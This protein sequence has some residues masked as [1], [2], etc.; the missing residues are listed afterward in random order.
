[1]WNPFIN[2]EHSSKQLDL[3]ILFIVPKMRNLNSLTI[4]Y[5]S[6]MKYISDTLCQ[7][8][9]TNSDDLGLI[10][11]SNT[12]S[13]IKADSLDTYFQEDSTLLCLQYILRSFHDIA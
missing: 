9:L 2:T 12:K 3:F 7:T 8:G 6:P 13:L 5:L 10:T 11:C 1:M 4:E